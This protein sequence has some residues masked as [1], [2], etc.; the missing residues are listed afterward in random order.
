M[1]LKAKCCAKYKK[2]AKACKSCPVMAQLSKAQRRQLIKKAK[3]RR[4]KAA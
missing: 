4:A 2:K 3:K 1:K